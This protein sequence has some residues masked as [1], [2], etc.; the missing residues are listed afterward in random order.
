MRTF[1]SINIPEEIKKEII[2]IQKKLPEFKGKKTAKENLHLTLKFLGETEEGKIKSVREKLEKINFQEFN[3]QI[4][5]IGIFD[6][7]NSRRYPRKIILWLHLKNC[8]NL[9]RKIDESLKELF[10]P[11]KRFMSH[12][13]IARINSLEDKKDFLKK[14]KS[15][16]IPKI[17][18]SADRFFI[19]KSELERTGPKYSVIEEFLLS[20]K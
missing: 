10:T 16:E 5:S 17:K 8:E 14:L 1:I 12:L 18:F 19:M 11:E 20:K 4:N 13:T 2:E 9:Q 15:I 7:R 6:N 3:I